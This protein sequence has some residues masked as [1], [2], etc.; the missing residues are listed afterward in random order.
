MPKPQS[1]WPL[2]LTTA[3]N[4]NF[5]RYFLP[6]TELTACLFG[7]FLFFSFFS[8]PLQ[9]FGALAHFKQPLIL[10]LR[11]PPAPPIYPW[12]VSLVTLQR[13]PQ[14]KKAFLTLFLLNPCPSGCRG[15]GSGPPPL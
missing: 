14:A 15:V 7:S 12:G 4:F 1:S 2:C 3:R 5:P 8:F 9:T 6:K 11:F 10:C 13:P